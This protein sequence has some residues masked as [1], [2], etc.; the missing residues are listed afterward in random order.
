MASWFSC[1]RSRG[2]V[3]HVKLVFPGGH[4]ELLDR[5]TP[6]AAVVARHPRFCVARPDVFR[7]PA[8][9]GAVAAPDTVLQLGHKYYVVPCSTVR[10]LQ[11]Y[12]AAAAASSSSVDVSSHRGGGDRSRSPSAAGA[13]GG[14]RGGDGDSAVTLRRHL[15]SDSGRER[16]YRVSGRKRWFRCL[17]NGSAAKV[18]R[19]SGREGVVVGHGGRAEAAV[20]A[21]EVDAK[22]AKE[23]EKAP[24]GGESPG[25][26]RRRGASPAN[27]A[28]FSW[29]PSLHSITEE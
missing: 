10:R 23:N 13:A 6:A 5:P 22:E 2:R 27:S 20:T 17:P 28:S 8:G 9:A 29:Q 26:R 16:G 11:K 21:K 3:L 7:E 24:G 18:R 12:A 19:T 4:V 15:A 25:R 1:S 14:K